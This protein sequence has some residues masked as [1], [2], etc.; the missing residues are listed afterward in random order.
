MK[1]NQLRYFVEIVKH[2][3]NISNAAE[4]LFTSQ[5]GVSKQIILLEEELQLQLFNRKG[6]HL[7]GLT[8][9]GEKI[10]AMA[11]QVLNQINDI[12][13]VADEYNHRQATLTIATTHTQARY[14]LP[15]IVEQFLRAY[16]QIRFNLQQG[17][18]R[19]VAELVADGEADLGLATE[20]LMEQ[21][22]VVALPCYQW[23]RCIITQPGHPLRNASSLTLQEVVKYPIITYEQGF[24]GRHKLDEAFAELGLNAQ[25]VLTAVDADVIKTYVRLG[26]GIGI[27]AEMA[28]NPNT[29]KDLAALDASGLFGV[30]VTQIGIRQDKYLNHYI[31]RF[32]ALAAPHLTEDAIDKAM[33]CKSV[34]GRQEMFAKF[35]IPHY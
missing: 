7:C 8:E 27:I 6:R 33:A 4:S 22:G 9:A 12:R 30:S 16:P 5:S 24:T 10:Y 32:I 28:F 31:Y 15:P 3:Q 13:Q 29:D 19:H 26:M 35:S 14:V 2:R 20:A 25:V 23:S 21:S 18:P 1:L 11:T 17:T 34:K